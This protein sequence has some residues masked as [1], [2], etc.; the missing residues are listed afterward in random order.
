MVCDLATAQVFIK[1]GK[2]KALG[3]STAKRIQ[4]FPNIPT[5]AESGYPGYEAATW[6]A[7]VAPAKTPKEIVAKLN[8]AFA[9]GLKAPAAVQQADLLA[10][11]PYPTTPERV[12]E[13]ARTEADKLNVAI[14]AKGISLD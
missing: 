1:E 12:T 11:E 7:I 13:F 6:T 8:E 10:I 4:K 2:V 14:K 9:Y 3:V 5:I